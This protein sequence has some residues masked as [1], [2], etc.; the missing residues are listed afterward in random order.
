MSN[1]QIPGSQATNL[2]VNNFQISNNAT[3]PNT[4]IDIAAGEARDS[5]NVYDIITSATI[6]IN[7]AVNGINGLD[8]GSLSTNKTYAIFVIGDSTNKNSAATL[9]SLSATAPTL[10]FGYDSFR[11]IGWAR[12]DGSSHFLLYYV[13]GN[14]THRSY[15]WDSMIS[16]LSAGIATSFTAIDLSAAVPVVDNTPVILYASLTPAT[17]GDKASFRPTGSSATT[18]FDMTGVV[19]AKAQD[20]QIKILSKLSSSLPKIDY[21]VTSGSDSL[22]LSVLGFEDYI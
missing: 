21:E 19:A 6:T 4:Q 7:A 2:Y 14:G 18:V 1:T 12:T 16:V 11:R 15:F 20:M 13:V 17:A 3:T 22:N 10:P 8:T 5:K 9:L